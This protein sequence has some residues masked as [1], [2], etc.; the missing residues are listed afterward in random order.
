M[1]RGAAR[2]ARSNAATSRSRATRWNAGGRRAGAWRGTATAGSGRRGRAA[3]LRARAPARHIWRSRAISTT[4]S[5]ID[6]AASGAAATGKRPAAGAGGARRSQ[7]DDGRGGDRRRR[8]H[9]PV[10][11][12]SPGARAWHPGGGARGGADRLGRLRPQWRVLRPGRQQARLRADGAALRRAGR[13]PSSSP[14]R[15]PASSWSAALPPTRGS[16]SSPPA[17]ANTISPI[18][19]AAGTS[20]RTLPARCSGCS[21]SAGSSGVRPRWRS[22]CCARRRPWLPGRPPLSRPASAALRARAGAGSGG[23]GARSTPALRSRHG[24]QD[25]GRHLLTT[26]WERS[27]PTGSCSRPTATPRGPAPA[28]RGRLLPALSSILVTRPLTAAEQAAQGWTG[29]P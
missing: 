13:P 17:R 21:A 2:T 29:R 16:T 22:A 19:P 7:G 15:R 20:W 4:P 24:R 25:G 6:R 27:P 5:H 26:P 14:H 12:L 3:S 1:P 23:R 8:L 11:R 9:R 10:R 28:L 18:A